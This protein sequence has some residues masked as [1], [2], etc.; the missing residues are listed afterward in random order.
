MDKTSLAGVLLHFWLDARV[1][2]STLCQLSILCVSDAVYPARVAARCYRPSNGHGA[3]H[4]LLSGSCGAV[5]LAQAQ[6]SPCQKLI[7]PSWRDAGTLLWLPRYSVRRRFD[8]RR[9]ESLVFF[10][11]SCFWFPH[12]PHLTWS[13]SLQ[14]LHFL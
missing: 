11:F 9:E 5:H 14:T 4:F 1:G 12:H 13:I 2:W 3:A 7:G 6:R 10:G 8:Y